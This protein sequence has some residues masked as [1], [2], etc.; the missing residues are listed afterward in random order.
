MIQYLKVRPLP[1]VLEGWRQKIERIAS[2]LGLDFF[3]TRFE[4]VSYDKMSEIASYGGFPTRYPHWRFGMEY[5]RLSKSH[6][7]GLSKIYELVINNDPCYAYLLEGNEFV[8]QK[9]VMAH[10]YGHADFFKHNFWFSRTNRRMLDTMANH[11]TRIRRYQD[12]YGVTV[13]EEFIDVC[14]SLENL[15]DLHSPYRPKKTEQENR[16]KGDLPDE[17]IGDVDSLPRLQAKEYMDEYVNPENFM[18]QQRKKQKDETDKKTKFPVS[19]QRDVMLFLMQEAPLTRWQRNVLGIVRDEAYYF[20]PQGMTK[21]LNEGWASYWHTHMMT[22]SGIMEGSE[23]ID[24][25]D[26]HSRCTVMHKGRLNPYKL[27]IELFRHI[28]E[29]WNQGRFGKEYEECSDMA[30]RANWNRQTGLGREKIFE[31]RKHHNDVTFLDEYLTP[32]F[33]AEHKLFTFGHNARA[34][35][36]QIASRDFKEVKTKLLTQLTNMGQPVIEV[37]DANFN[38]RSELLL[39][40]R[41]DGVDLDVSY[42]QATLQ[43]LYRLWKRPVHIATSKGDRPT[44]LSFDGKDHSEGEFD[45][46]A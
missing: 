10:V 29:R 4:M 28:E 15:I 44:L 46:S 33:C 9:L 17:L 8:D 40:H 34:N 24:Y 25:A 27:G 31:V 7:Y 21:I 35:E 36:W 2:D 11:A 41:H 5:E 18:E 39:T 30:E 13:V 43:N 42:G 45:K 16:P 12:L 6:T 38:N 32:E 20:A 26:R 14:L 1:D 19:A 3:D 23:V 37:D 22:R